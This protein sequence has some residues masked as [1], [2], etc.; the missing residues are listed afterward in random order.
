MTIL[1]IYLLFIN[2][3]HQSSSKKWDNKTNNLYG[4][5]FHL[6][7][8]KKNK[9]YHDK[10]KTEWAKV[11]KIT[12]MSFYKLGGK[13]KHNNPCWVAITDKWEG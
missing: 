12:H 11:S 6:S 10:N 1:L 2:S 13:S 3:V 5:N 9:N 8:W 7:K 4:P